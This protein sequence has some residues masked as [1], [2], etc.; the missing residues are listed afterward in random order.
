M[1]PTQVAMIASITAVFGF[2]VSRSV[3]TGFISSTIG[4]GGA[5]VLGKTVVSSLLKLIPGVGSA[6]GS[7]I[8]SATAGIIT[9][10]LGETYILI[11]CAVFKGEISTRDL[12]TE[13][14]KKK[15]MELFK[16]QL[17]MG[18]NKTK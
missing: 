8:S 15:V 14:G 5:T 12:E 1:I 13:E 16:E 10:A 3:I 9:T 6:T 11:M 4:A 7:A 17:S 18:G 2:D